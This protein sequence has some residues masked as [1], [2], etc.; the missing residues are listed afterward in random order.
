MTNDSTINL[1]QTRLGIPTARQEI[2]KTIH[3]SSEM[4]SL[5]D[6][7][8]APLQ[9]RFLA[10]CEGSRGLPMTYDP[11]FKFIFNPDTHPDRLAAL[12]SQI[13]GEKVNVKQALLSESTRIIEESS[14]LIMDIVVELEN[15]S[16]AN[17]EIQKIPY[18]FCGERGACY[19]SDLVLR[20]YSRYKKENGK[21]FKYEDMRKVY[22]IV[23]LEKSDSKFHDFPN[24]FLHFAK[25]T[26]HTGLELELLQEY[27]FIPLDIF[28]NISQNIDTELDA[29]LHFLISDDP[30]IIYKIIQKFP[31]F[32][33]FYQEVISFQTDIKEVLSMFSE[34][35]KIMDKNT[36]QY[37]VDEMQKDIDKL[38][39]ERDNAI[40]EKDTAIAEKDTA[41]AEKDTAIAE[42]DTAIA[43]K[44]SL[45][46]ENRRLLE[47]LK[48]YQK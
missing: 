19:S 20:Q 2:L 38:A 43:E 1:T 25:Q 41:I 26:F 18:A 47:L 33:E 16:L 23:L 29:W 15:G 40:T 13:L 5:Y 30:A 14:L 6:S 42:K 46:Q 11:F 3:S 34:A 45:E 32:E 31:F 37:M 39:A 44:Q 17:V 4:N 21:D 9:E 7:L 8:V 10:F 28:K 12:L 48:Q 27:V 24:N 36:V 22:T 35:L